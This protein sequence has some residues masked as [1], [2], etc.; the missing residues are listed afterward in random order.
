MCSEHNSDKESGV[1]LTD[2]GPCCTFQ[3]VFCKYFFCSTKSLIKSLWRSPSKLGY[4]KAEGGS[5]TQYCRDFWMLFL[6]WMCSV[7]PQFLFHVYLMKAYKCPRKINYGPMAKILT[8]QITNQM[9]GI[10]TLAITSIWVATDMPNFSN[11]VVKR[12]GKTVY[13]IIHKPQN[14]LWFTEV[15]FSRALVIFEEV[16][17]SNYSKIF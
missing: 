15:I 5:S 10:Y 17:L 13:H 4:W 11:K 16:L 2:D 6:V 8:V 7:W 12:E 3:S 9:K 1:F 14:S